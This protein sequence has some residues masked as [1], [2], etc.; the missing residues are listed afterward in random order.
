[1]TLARVS[2][3][4]RSLT[5][6][7]LTHDKQLHASTR[8]RVDGEPH[9]ECDL[10]LTLDHDRQSHE[11]NPNVFDGDVAVALVRDSSSL[12]AM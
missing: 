7:W 8:I 6:R 9:V 2:T 5:R 1:M 4:E 10:V 3:F 11:P 12:V